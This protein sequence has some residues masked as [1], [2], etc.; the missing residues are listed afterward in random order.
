MSKIQKAM[1]LAAGRGVRMRELT[2]ERPKPLIPV[3]GKPIIDYIVDKSIRHG[4]QTLVVNTCYKGE[5][6]QADL[7]KYKNIHIHYSVEDVALETGGGVK[8]ALPLLGNEPFFVMNADPVWINKTTSVFEQLEA[9]WDPQKYDVLLALI[10]LSQARGAVKDGNY[11]IENGK[12]RRQRPNEKNIPYMFMGVQ[13]IHP[14]VFQSIPQEHTFFSLREIY[15]SAQEAGRL[16][17]I[18][19]DGTWYHVGTPE[20]LALTEKELTEQTDSHLHNGVNTK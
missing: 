12:A 2:N 17:H 1:I 3:C 19:F 4:I 10:P 11:F 15:D 20:A 6:I 9:A 7:A 13:I 18:I 16:G 14:C 8:N 5:M